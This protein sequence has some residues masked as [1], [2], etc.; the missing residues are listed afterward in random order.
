LGIATKKGIESI[1][2]EAAAQETDGMDED[3]VAYEASLAPKSSC[4]E[5]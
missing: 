1:V 4:M 5:R 3:T 2:R